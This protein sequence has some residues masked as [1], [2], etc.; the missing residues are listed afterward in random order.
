METIDS[1]GVTKFDTRGIIGIIYV[2]DQF[3]HCY[4]PNVKAVGPV[5][6]KKI[7][8]LICPTQYATFPSVL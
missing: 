1:R 8:S 6:S 4:I 7:S 5:L 2:E 3:S